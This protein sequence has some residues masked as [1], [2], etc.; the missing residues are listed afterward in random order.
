MGKEP[1]R[2]QTH[3]PKLLRQLD[4]WKT[5]CCVRGAPTPVPGRDDKERPNMSE[6]QLSRDQ[7]KDYLKKNSDYFSGTRNAGGSS[8]PAVKRR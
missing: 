7:V 8:A 1:R 6:A 2:L 3:R 5:N 4:K